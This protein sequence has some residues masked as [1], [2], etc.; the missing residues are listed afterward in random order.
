MLAFLTACFYSLYLFALSSL[1]LAVQSYP[2][3]VLLWSLL[4]PLVGC[5]LCAK[6]IFEHNSCSS[7]S[8]EIQN[9]VEGNNRV[10]G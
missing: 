3:I 10:G 2:F 9:K 6:L 4:D 7:I 8:Q 1:L 5:P